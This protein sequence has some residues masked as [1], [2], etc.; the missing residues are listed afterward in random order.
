MTKI[1]EGIKEN[2]LAF[3]TKVS[4]SIVGNIGEFKG[5]EKL[6]ESYARIAAINAL[7]LDIVE[8]HFPE[9]A[10]HFFYEAHND[11]LISHVNASFGSWRPALQALR[12]FMENT[13]SAIYYLDHPVEYMKWNV[14]DFRMSPKEM[15]QYLSEHPKLG[16][17]AKDINLKATLDSEYGTLSKAVHGSNSMFRMTSADGKTNIANPSLE[18]LGKWSARE[19]STVDVCITSLVGV[20]SEHLEGAKRQNL[21]A[22]LGIAIQSK[23]R[24]ALKKHNGVSIH[25]P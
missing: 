24:A 23:S 13:L 25:A 10:A 6:V 14:G 16:K 19:R 8:P 20:L 15:R 7:K 11:S 4:D 12:S 3:S 18:E 21:R 1:D 22:A 9:G 5:N 2:Y 17:L